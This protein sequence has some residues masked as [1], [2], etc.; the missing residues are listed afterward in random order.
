[1]CVYLWWRG[2]NEQWD[3]PGK[4]VAQRVVSQAHVQRQHKN[5]S[6]SPSDPGIMEVSSKSNAQ[7]TTHLQQW[8]P[9]KVISIVKS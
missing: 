1:M 2:A 6:Q 8:P 4:E 7:S 9:V 5:R 3:V